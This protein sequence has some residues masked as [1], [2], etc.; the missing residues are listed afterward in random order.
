MNE[1]SDSEIAI[2]EKDITLYRFPVYYHSSRYDVFS[3]TGRLHI[4]RLSHLQYWAYV[5][6]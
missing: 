3:L 1:E 6:V 5:R 2:Y 4:W